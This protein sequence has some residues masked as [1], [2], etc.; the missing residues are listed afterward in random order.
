MKT[1]L[2]FGHWEGDLTIFEPIR[3]KTNL[4]DRAQKPLHNSGKNDN[5]KPAPVI[6]TIRDR[7]RKLPA[8]GRQTITFDPGWRYSHNFLD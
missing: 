8:Y 6:L 2:L 5:R 4:T 3:G 1:R 7:L